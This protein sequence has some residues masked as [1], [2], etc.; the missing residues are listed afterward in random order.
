M[1]RAGVTSY[2]QADGLGSITSVRDGGGALVASYTYDAFGNLA[3]STGT[4]TNPFRYTGR[5]FDAETGLYY[6]RARYYDPSMGRFI[7]EDPTRFREANNFYTYVLNNP[8]VFSDPTGLQAK[9]TAWQRFKDWWRNW[10]NESSLKGGPTPFNICNEGDLALF[11]ESSPVNPYRGRDING[12]TNPDIQ[13]AYNTWEG[14]FADRCNAL[15]TQ[16]KNVYP[17]CSKSPLSY[18]G[19]SGFCYCCEVCSKKPKE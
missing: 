14:N 13:A 8:T 2:Y 11:Y 18:G 4:L 7:G 17:I 16:G 3:A 10:W 1:L 12:K 19:T 9:P 6:Y 5:E 15:R